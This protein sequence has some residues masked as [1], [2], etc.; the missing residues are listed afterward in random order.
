MTIPNNPSLNEE[1]TNDA[2]GVTYVWDG[3]RW[4]IKPGETGDFVTQ[5]EFEAGQKRQDDD[6]EAGFDTQGSI[7]MKNIEQDQTLATQ[8]GQINALETQVQLLAG[9]RA[10]GRWEYRRRIESNSP[11][12]PADKCFYGTHKDN[13]NTVLRNWSDINLLMINK[14]D[15][16]GNTFAFSQFEEGDKVEVLASDGSSAVYGTVTNNPSNDVYANMILAVERSNGGPVEGAEYLISAYRP[17]SSNGNVDLDILDGRYLIKTGDTMTGTL[18]TD[19]LIKSVRSSGYAFEVKPDNT[20]DATAFIHTNGNAQFAATSFN[21]VIS[22]SGDSRIKGFD[23]DGNEKIKIYPSGLV[24]TKNEIRIDR[25]VS[26]EQCLAIKQNGTSKF[27]VRADGKAVSQYAVSSSDD[28]KVLTTKEYVDQAL[29][30]SLMP[31]PAQLAWKYKT[32]SSTSNP[33]DGYFRVANDGSNVYYRLSM[34]TANGVDLTNG[35]FSD[36]NVNI[37][38]GPVGCIW[39]WSSSNQNWKLKQQFRIDYWRWNYNNH[40]EFRRTSVHGNSDGSFTADYQYYITVGGF[41]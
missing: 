37:Q 13:I 7:L 28:A 5:T 41:F 12:P 2:T 10:V 26:T 35:A 34:K 18:N 11:R 9:V 31:K 39:F 19:S 27:Y 24:E 33:G 38:Y 29:T 3:E 16:D 20:G 17:G 36:T 1:W 40:M 4:F 30:E 15:L 21:D 14:T 25:S 22:F 32:G 8:S 6:I 23:E